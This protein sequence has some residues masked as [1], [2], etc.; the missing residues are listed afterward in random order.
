MRYLVI[1]IIG[2]A[3]AYHFHIKAKRLRDQNTE[4]KAE[5]ADL[6]SKWIDFRVE[7]GENNYSEEELV[8]VNKQLEI[9]ERESELLRESVKSKGEAVQS[10][11]ESISSLFKEYRDRIREEAKGMRFDEMT[12]KD[13]RHY[14]DVEI[15]EVRPDGISFRHSKGARGLDLDEVPD[16]WIKGFLYTED[17]LKKAK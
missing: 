17:E 13:G 4:L 16:D 8:K 7:Q 15:T 2:L 6:K 11:R 3:V 10:L 14:V 9:L 12:T 1:L 5:I